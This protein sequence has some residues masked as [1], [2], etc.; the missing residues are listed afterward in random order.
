[1]SSSKDVNPSNGETAKLRGACVHHDNGILGA[2][3]FSP[4]CGP[5]GPG[6]ITLTATAAGCEPAEILITA[7]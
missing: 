6:K 1:V 2:A 3:T 7:E 4:C 5:A